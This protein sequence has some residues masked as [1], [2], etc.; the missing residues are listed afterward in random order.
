M[1][2][3][4]QMGITIAGVAVVSAIAAVVFNKL[5]PETRKEIDGLPTRGTQALAN[6]LPSHQARHEK[7]D[8]LSVKVSKIVIC[9]FTF[10]H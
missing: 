2:D 10:K 8:F 9:F 5:N 4:S 6:P 7:S 1:N 3:T